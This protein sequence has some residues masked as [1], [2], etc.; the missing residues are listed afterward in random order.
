M[1]L[2]KWLRVLLAVAV[3]CT[4][5]AAFIGLVGAHSAAPALAR[6]Q[7]VPAILALNFAALAGIALVT[8]LVGRVYCSV[9]CPLGIFQ[10]V[11][12]RIRSWFSKKAFVH[13]APWTKTR[14]A[15]FAA[16]VAAALAGGCA[17]VALVEPYGVFGRM[18][19]AL[20][21]PLAGWVRNLLVWLSERAGYSF[22]MKAEVFVKGGL[23]LAVAAGS[24]VVIAFLAAWNGR[25]W[26]NAVCPAGT[27]LSALSH[28][29]LLRLAIDPAKCIGCGACERVCKA[30]CVDF[31]A[32][33]LDDARCVRCF[34]CAAACPRKAIGF[35][36]RS[37]NHE[38]HEK[39]DTNDTKVRG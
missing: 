7:L 35:T 16:C 24:F 34:D 31:K 2:L 12:L 6:G 21:A 8:L 22:I 29:P 28:R 17:L 19:S 25:F 9:L 37:A 39:E 32:H 26:C 23:A 33:A 1:K 20:L 38:T 4:F 11:V 13:E 30:R 18:A 5:A 15:V 14:W 36:V 10:D 27:L 3:F